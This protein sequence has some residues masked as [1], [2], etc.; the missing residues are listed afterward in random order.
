MITISKKDIW[1][2]YFAQFFNISAGIIVLPLIL[3]ML[4]V[5]EIGMNYLM[6]TIGSMVALF[7]FGFAPQF[8][9][10]ITYV[11]SG[12]QELMKEGVDNTQNK[13]GINYRLL[14]NMIHTAKYVYL[15]LAVIVLLLMLTLGSLY[16]NNITNG[17]SNVD[18]SF[19]IWL[20]FSISTFF[21][22]YYSYYTSLLTGKGL[23]MESKKAVVLSRLTYILLT[24]TF[25]YFGLGLLAVALANLIAPFVSRY[26]AYYYFFTPEF[27][28]KIGVHKISKQEKIELFK[29]IWH[30][31]KKLGIVYVCGYVITKLSLFMA[32]LYLSLTDIASFGLMIQLVTLITSVSATLFVT[33]QPMF[34]SLRVNGNNHLLMK[35][36]AFCM[37][38]QYLLYLIGTLFL[39]FLGPWILS[40]IGSN[41]TLPSRLILLLYAL[42]VLLETNHSNFATIIVTKNNI[43]F[44]KSGIISSGCIAL[45]SFLSL[46]YTSL[47][48]LG[49]ILVQG[50]TQ[51]AY[52][53]WKWPHVV[54]KEFN[55]YFISFL[56]IGVKESL[57]HTIQ[58]VPWLKK[59][60]IILRS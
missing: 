54:L 20:I 28:K 46:E 44:V 51:L 10:N 8:G 47:G 39:V 3:R 48:I 56:L 24:C 50:L 58:Y 31:S 14:A 35:V 27:R 13:S 15:K 36:F 43:P 55:I 9:R 7:D 17:F 34:S 57:N 12:A 19:V 41:A 25:L 29:I 38:V 53:N 45:G 33:Y 40:L 5:E 42:V 4:S 21:N 26:I 1:W 23:I 22:I 37:N 2:S 6:L 16:I 60:P 11:F 30:N 18:N 52:N 32:G 49:L 59:I